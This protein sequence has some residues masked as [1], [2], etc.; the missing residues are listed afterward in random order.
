MTNTLAA[1]VNALHNSGFDAN[2]NIGLD[3]F[4]ITD[5]G[6]SS[7]SIGINPIIAA[8][9]NRIAASASVSG[10][11]ENA[12][13]I[14]AVRDEF[15][16]NDHKETLSGFLA[17][18]VGEIG[19]QTADAKTN[20]EHQ[21]AVMNYLSNQ[22]DSISGVSIDEEMIL[23]TKYQMGYTAAGKLCTMVDDMLNILMNIIR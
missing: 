6:N 3:F 20:N 22:R 1:R 9:I 21:T 18:M 12:T 2:G 8:D 16:M 17:S 10:D 7:G 5:T 14:A 19:R 15:L 23:L 4:R 13:R 11:G